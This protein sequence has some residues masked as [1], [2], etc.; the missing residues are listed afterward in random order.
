MPKES[1][2]EIDPK[3]TK[4]HILTFWN[5]EQYSSLWIS[6][7]ARY[8]LSTPVW[9]WECRS[10]II[11]YDGPDRCMMPFRHTLMCVMLK[12]LCRTALNLTHM[13]TCE[14]PVTTPLD[15][16]F[17]VVLYKFIFFYIYEHVYEGRHFWSII[18]KRMLNGTY[19]HIDDDTMAIYMSIFS[20]EQLFVCISDTQSVSGSLSD[21][22]LNLVEFNNEVFSSL[23]HTKTI[24]NSPDWISKTN[25]WFNV[26][27][28]W[29]FWT[30]E[31]AHHLAKLSY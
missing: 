4:S 18:I 31:V 27:K 25:W 29:S 17:K 13:L 7:L 9:V 16:R 1:Y 11:K 2:L 15:L 30:F 14:E 24:I 6:W 22:S 19:W 10:D 12:K 21:V 3:L 20:R 28:W 23:G 8:R 5:I 26:M